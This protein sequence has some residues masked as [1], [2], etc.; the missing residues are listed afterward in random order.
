MKIS[1]EGTK[2]N[3]ENSD[4][5]SAET[6]NVAS[7]TTADNTALADKEIQK[8]ASALPKSG[9]SLFDRAGLGAVSESETEDGTK[10]RS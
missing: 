1:D 5:E 10:S 7:D 2:E 3:T 6:E 4:T 8:A 9:A